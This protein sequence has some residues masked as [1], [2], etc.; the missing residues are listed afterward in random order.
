MKTPEGIVSAVLVPSRVKFDYNGAGV[1][2]ELATRYPFGNRLVYTVQT[3]R[4]IEFE[5]AIR[6]P[7]F[8][9]SA[10][11]DG[12]DAVPG[13]IARIRRMW[14]GTATV[15]AELDFETRMVQRPSSMYCVER[16]PLLFSLPIAYTQNRVEYT[17]KGVE[18]KFPYCDYETFAAEKWN[19]AFAGE[20]FEYE[21]YEIGDFP[22]AQ[23]TPP[24][25]LKAVMQEIPWRIK[26]GYR[27]ICSE[28]PDS[29]E[30][31]ADKCIKKLI[32]YGS[33]MLR[34]TEMP[35]LK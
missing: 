32:P 34:M 23:E 6:I 17:D 19:F 13:T 25:A 16:G 18:R 15:I 21:E 3:N 28:L 35:L 5:L 24:V 29:L 14:N 22:F 2:V 11:I 8:A 31:V 27:G 1:S 26:E 33:T 30:P 10:R 20:S 12:K 9:V 7:G 4:E